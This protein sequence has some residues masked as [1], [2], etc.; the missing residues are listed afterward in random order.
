MSSKDGL[1]RTAGGGLTE[2]DEAV[3]DIA[4]PYY[5]DNQY[6]WS[7]RASRAPFLMHSIAVVTWQR[8]QDWVGISHLSTKS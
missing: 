5:Y 8:Q 3:W 2:E 1:V 6:D 4:E 7:Q